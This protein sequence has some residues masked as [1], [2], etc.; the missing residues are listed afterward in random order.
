MEKQILK[1]QILSDLAIIKKDVDAGYYN[2]LN[3]G[4]YLENL[5][6]IWFKVSQLIDE[7][8]YGK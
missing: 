4:E 6:K 5:N 1:N 8:N 3:T 2:F 7:I